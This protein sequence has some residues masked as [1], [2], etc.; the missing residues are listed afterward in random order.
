MHEEWMDTRRTA[1]TEVQLTGAPS[2]L[3]TRRAAG[4]AQFSVEYRPYRIEVRSAWPELR[5]GSSSTIVH[6]YC[7]EVR[8]NG[9]INPLKVTLTPDDLDEIPEWL[10]SIVRNAEARNFG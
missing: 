4:T 8:W 9:D 10:V 6:L 5:I 3:V 1:S 2:V 7:N